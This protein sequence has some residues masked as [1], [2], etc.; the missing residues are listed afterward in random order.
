M[1]ELLVVMIIIGVLGLLATGVY[2]A[3]IR[4]AEDTVLNANIQT[5]AEEVQSALAL[6]PGLTG[7]ALI[8]E[9]SSRTNLVWDDDWDSTTSDTS[10]QVRFEIIQ[11]GTTVVAPAASGT[12]PTVSWLLDGNSAVRL[13][14]RDGDSAVWRCALIILK[15]SAASIQRLTATVY[16]DDGSTAA[17]PLATAHEQIVGGSTPAAPTKDQ[18]AQFAAEMRGVWFDGGSSQASNGVHDCS[19]VANTSAPGASATQNDKYLPHDSQ[20]WAI[21]AFDAAFLDPSS[22]DH[23][24]TSA[25]TGKRTLHRS[26]SSLDGE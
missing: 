22:T 4:T 11:Q 23:P 6:N 18:A 17:Q 24:S 20:T 13:H 15:P 12:A 19:P 16:E 7:Q 14:I 10:E 9:L 8:T 21:A 5:A 25:T 2:F 26:P 1:N 3:F